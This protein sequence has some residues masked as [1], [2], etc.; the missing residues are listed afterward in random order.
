MKKW[1]LGSC[2]TESDDNSDEC[3]FNDAIQW[4]C[5]I[6]VFWHEKKGSSQIKF[7]NDN[8]YQEITDKYIIANKKFQNFKFHL[9]KKVSKKRIHKFS[10]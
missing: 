10:K 9:C 2:V 5:L 4:S 3:W 6:K 7:S 8:V 1:C